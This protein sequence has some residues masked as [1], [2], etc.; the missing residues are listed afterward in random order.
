M[1]PIAVTCMLRFKPL[2]CDL[3]TRERR[4]AAGKHKRC[5]GYS[6]QD[7]WDSVEQ[8]PYAFA[9]NKATAVEN[10]GRPRWARPESRSLGR[11]GIVN[12]VAY[13]SNF[14]L[15]LGI[16]SSEQITL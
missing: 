10:Y 14:G 7:A 5:V 12:A 13:Y 11:L 6:I 8:L 16:I 1:D 3:I 9:L 2:R 15:H 4:R